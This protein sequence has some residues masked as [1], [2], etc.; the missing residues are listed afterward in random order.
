MLTTWYSESVIRITLLTSVA[1]VSVSSVVSV[2]SG[3]SVSSV[4]SVDSVTSVASVFSVVSVF[5][6]DSVTSVASVF[7]VVSVTS[8][9]SVFSVVSVT[10]VVLSFSV[11]PVVSVS[12][13]SVTF[14]L[15]VTSEAF[16]FFASSFVWSD[17]SS[18][19]TSVSPVCSTTC[20]FAASAANAMVSE[21]MIIAP[22]NVIHRP[23]FNHSSLF[24]IITFCLP[25]SYFSLL[26]SFCQTCPSLVL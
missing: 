20:P 4:F 2:P 14:V 26:G 22:A 6:V 7:S 10:S 16:S 3:F 9:V 18:V 19:K 25:S 17:C 1:F 12:A 24:F 13:C 15:S 21:Q 5:S 11:V 23:R 8:V